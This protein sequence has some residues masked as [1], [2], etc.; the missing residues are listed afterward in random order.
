MNDFHVIENPDVIR[1]AEMISK[2]HI[3]NIYHPAV[4]LMGLLAVSDINLVH[5]PEQNARVIAGDRRKRNGFKIG[6]LGI[7]KNRRL[8]DNGFNFLRT[9]GSGFA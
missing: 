5:G 4:D 1:T 7:T 3:F 2:G 6:A 8:P 9:A